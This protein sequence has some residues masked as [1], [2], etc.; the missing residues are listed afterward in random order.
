MLTVEELL[1]QW[2]TIGM[3]DATGERDVNRAT[4]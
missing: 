1:S 3:S 2:F 4:P